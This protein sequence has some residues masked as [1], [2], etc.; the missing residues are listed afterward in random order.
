MRPDG[1]RTIWDFYFY[2][3]KD[4]SDPKVPSIDIKRDLWCWPFHFSWRQAWQ[5]WSIS[6]TCYFFG[7]SVSSSRV[8]LT[9]RWH[10]VRCYP[11][12]SGLCIEVSGIELWLGFAYLL[13]T[14][15][16]LRC[17]LTNKTREL[18][19]KTFHNG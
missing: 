9:K 15:H 1:T 14:E 8:C 17:S 12:W 6:L 18:L 3:K 19:R 2:E 13:W 7:V 5:R 11:R 16:R 10:F 4:K